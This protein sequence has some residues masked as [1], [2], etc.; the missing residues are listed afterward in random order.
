MIYSLSDDLSRKLVQLQSE[1]ELSSLYEDERLRHSGEHVSRPL[2]THLRLTTHPVCLTVMNRALPAK[3]LE[4]C[5]LETILA[6]LPDAYKH[7]MFASWVAAHFVY[8]YGIDASPVEF[9][10]FLNSLH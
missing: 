3:L 5:G 8:S 4:H 6:R 2:Q 7:S 9:Y 10:Q 1:L